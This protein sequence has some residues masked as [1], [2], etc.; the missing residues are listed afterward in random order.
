[1]PRCIKP[2]LVWRASRPSLTASK[3]HKRMRG[4]TYETLG[5]VSERAW[6]WFFRMR[7]RRQ[8]TVQVG[9]G[10]ADSLFKGFNAAMIERRYEHY[11]RGKRGIKRTTSTG[12]SSTA[13][14]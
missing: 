3:L 1:M 14:G 11:L 13:K 7:L 12:S 5:A 10:M 8:G 2:S 4:E 9:S 6:T